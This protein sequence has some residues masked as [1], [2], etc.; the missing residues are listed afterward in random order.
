V[1]AAA[2]SEVLVALEG[3]QAFPDD[4]F[5]GDGAHFYTRLSAVGE[6]ADGRALRLSRRF[7]DPSAGGPARLATDL[8][9]AVGRLIARIAAATESAGLVATFR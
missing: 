4:S 2:L 5:A 1:D 8:D 6:L 7:Y 9:Q 3:M